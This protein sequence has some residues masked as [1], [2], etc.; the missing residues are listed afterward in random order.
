MHVRMRRRSSPR[1]SAVPL[2]LSSR[3]SPFLLSLIS[4]SLSFWLFLAPFVFAPPECRRTASYPSER[5]CC[6]VRRFRPGRTSGW[7]QRPIVGLPLA[8]DFFTF[9]R[10]ARLCLGLSWFPSLFCLYTRVMNCVMNSVTPLHRESARL[11]SLR[12]VPQSLA[13]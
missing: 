4:R 2:Q 8:L 10:A 12:V 11:R 9:L 5:R 6:I 3:G 1:C 13:T 7:H